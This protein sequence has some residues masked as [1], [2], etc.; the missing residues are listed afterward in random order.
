M[1]IAIPVDTDKKTIFKKTGHAA[2]FAVYEND[3]VINYITNNH[4]DGEHGQHSE[5][6]HHE[7]D[8]EHVAHHKKDISELEGC[9]VILVQ[10]IGE[11]MKS[12]IDSLGIKVQKIRKKDGIT[13]DEAIKNYLNNNI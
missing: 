1:K 11:H 5:H 3:K 10:A 9:D 6:E 8:E 2:F 7:S 13:A 12:A 4:G